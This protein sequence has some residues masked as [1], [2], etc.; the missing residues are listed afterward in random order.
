MSNTWGNKIG[1]VVAITFAL[2]LG[3]GRV[4]ASDWQIDKLDDGG[5]GKFSSMMPDKYGNLHLVYIADDGQRYPVKYAFWDHQ[6]KRWFVMP[7]AMGG[8]FCSLTLD[9]EQ[10][11]H[12]AWA[13]WGTMSGAKLRYAHWD[14]GT[15]KV[16]TV[17]LNADTISYYTSIVLDSHDW[18][19]ISFYEYNGPKG[20]DFRV[21]QRVVRWNGQYWEVQTV[22]GQ[23]QSG[24]FNALGIDGKDHVHLAYANVNGMTAGVRYGYWNGSSWKLEIVEG[25]PSSEAYFGHGL[26]L[27][28]DKDGNPNISYLRY[29]EPYSVKYAVRRNGQWHIETVDQLAG[30]GYPDRNGITLDAAGRPW[31]SYFDAGEGALKLAHR[32]DNRW[33]TEIVDG[34][35]VGF[36]SSVQ[37]DQGVIWVAYADERGTGLKVAH[38]SLESP[39]SPITGGPYPASSSKR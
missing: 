26:C 29:S 32:E 34:N 36:T 7:I 39:K 15:W 8:S 38:R 10:H 30:V 23:N 21:R 1:A 6:L 12:I 14:S 13:D 28:M 3:A 24:K 16:E 9:S 18:P 19:I 22:D 2:L 27:V 35:G 37:V 33:V 5:I 31:I 20:T 25:L 17:P 4:V 11:P